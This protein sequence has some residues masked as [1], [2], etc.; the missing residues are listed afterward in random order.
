[1]HER[2]CTLGKHDAATGFTGQRGLDDGLG[3]SALGQ[4]VGR[5]D[6]AVAGRG[7]QHLGQ[8]LLARQVDPGGTPAEMV[9]G[10][11]SPDRA[12]ELVAGVAE[13]DQR[14]AGFGAEG[15]RD[16]S[17]DIVDARRARRPPGSAG[18]RWTRSGCRS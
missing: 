17:A 10:D 4:I 3:Q 12:V 1:M 11:L 6:Q 2:V 9:G 15:S 7:G 5:G 14:L 18:S 8:Q 16:A 13:Q